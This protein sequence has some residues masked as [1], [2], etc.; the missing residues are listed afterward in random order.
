MDEVLADILNTCLLQISAGVSVD[1]C[2][3]AYPQQRAAL[4]APLRAA[5]RLRGLPRPALPAAAQTALETRMLALAAQRRAAPALPAAPNGPH[6]R[7]SGALGPA[8]LLAGA[9]RALGYRGPLSLPWLRL[10]SAA[11][12]LLLVL[13]LGAGA[14]AAARVIV[15]I[16]QGPP[17]PPTSAPPASSRFTLDGPIEQM[18]PERWVVRGSAVAIGAQT[19]ITGTPR[20]GA[21]ARISGVVR[22]D[23]AR[24]AQTITIGAPPTPGAPPRPTL[25]PSPTA[26]TR[27]PTPKPTAT[28]IPTKT[29]TPRPTATRLPAGATVDVAGV[30]QRISIVN[31]FTTI[32]VNDVTYVLPPNLVVILGER[33]RIDAPIVFVGRVNATGQII[34]INVVEINN[35]RIIINPPGNGG[36]D[37]DDDDDDD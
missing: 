4:E 27:T 28:P 15:R 29:P 22:A 11:I 33:L 2:L 23:G 6:P 1:D 7:S 32:V 3:A 17:A 13:A 12:A 26:A 34:I 37:D 21:R 16:I 31:N 36:D 8:A 20:L 24:L 10:A 14:L 25:A 18:T 19:T 35:Q 5:Q 30:V 9:L